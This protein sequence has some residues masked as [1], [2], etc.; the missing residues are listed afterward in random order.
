MIHRWFGIT[1]NYSGI[2][3]SA[4]AALVLNY[5]KLEIDKI[6]RKN[7]NGFRKNRPPISQILTICRIIKG[8]RANKLE[9]TLLFVDFLQ[10][11]PKKL[12]Q[13]L[14]HFCKHT[15]SMVCVT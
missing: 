2:I 9:A 7:Q 12:L 15:N 4:I 3:F 13:I 5:I 1:K 14:W 6:F 10:S 11:T 8:V